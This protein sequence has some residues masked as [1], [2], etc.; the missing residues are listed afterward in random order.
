MSKEKNMKEIKIKVEGKEWKDAVDKA[1]KK[2]SSKVKVDGFRPGK[3]PRDMII[4]KYGQ[5]NLW[6]DAADESIQAAYTKVMDENKCFTTDCRYTYKKS[7][8]YY[9]KTTIS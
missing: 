8:V 1:Y 7:S 9:S 4:K 5:G 2:I 3:A 6:M